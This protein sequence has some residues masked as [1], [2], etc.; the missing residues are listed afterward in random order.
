MQD[1]TGKWHLWED[2]GGWS[3]FT[4]WDL[5]HWNG[6]VKSSTHMNGLTGSVSPTPS[7][8]YAF[9]PGSLMNGTKR[10]SA[11]VSAV[12]ED[13]V[14]G[15]GWSR[16]THRGVAL[17]LTVPAREAPGSFRDPMRAFQF[18]GSWFV[19]VGCGES[20]HSPGGG[21]QVCLFKAKNDTLASLLLRWQSSSSSK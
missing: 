13:C 8:V 20:V 16:W 18:Q 17:G 5:M 6:T 11:I 15:M 12:C 21:A 3:N 2:E 14:P 1:S 7:G 19:G 9:W 4:S 10:V